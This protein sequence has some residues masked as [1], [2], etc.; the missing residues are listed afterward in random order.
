MSTLLFHLIYAPR[1]IHYNVLLIFGTQSIV[2]LRARHS[3]IGLTHARR[4]VSV[5]HLL[6]AE[7]WRFNSPLKPIAPVRHSD[8]YFEDDDIVTGKVSF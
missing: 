2:F 1:Y 3:S 6:H 4:A 7:N 5:L 8:Y